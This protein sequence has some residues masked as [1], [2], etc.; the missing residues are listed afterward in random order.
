MMPLRFPILGA[1]LALAIGSA[2]AQAS[3]CA[4]NEQTVWSCASKAKVY[5][6]CAPMPTSVKADKAYLQYRVGTPKHI[7]FVYPSTLRPPAGI[8]KYDLRHITAN[9][10]FENQGYKYVIEEN[11]NGVASVEV[12]RGDTTIAQVAC[13]TST[14]TL[15]LT[16]TMQQFSEMGIRD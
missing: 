6:L 9:I 4:S 13:R 8:F 14:N 3:L 7:E 2:W 16:T 15:T 5:S 12:S 11:I 10:E 1:A